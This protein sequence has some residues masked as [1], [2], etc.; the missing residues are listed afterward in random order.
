MY[1]AAI[2]SNPCFDQYHI[3]N[4]CPLLGDVLAN[5]GGI[6][7]ANTTYFNRTDVKK[8]IHAPEDTQWLQCFPPGSSPFVGNFSNPANPLSGDGPQGN[9]DRS[10][11]SIQRVL[12][13]VIDAT[14]RVL[15]GNGNLDALQTTNNT[16][17]SIQNMTFGGK[18]G[19]QHEPSKPFVVNMVDK[20]YN[21]GGAQGTVGKWHFERG[22]MWVETFGA[23]H[24]LSANQP[25]AAL[26]HLE[27]LLGRIEDF[28]VGE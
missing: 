28:E 11:D 19:F 2:D 8:A 24:Y 21:V 16:L 25:R 1:L 12:P 5:P 7:L 15:I 23:G 17:L 6:G 14:Q 4:Y 27:W 20:E 10:P 13:Q 3:T 9:N 18:L 22:L 26:R